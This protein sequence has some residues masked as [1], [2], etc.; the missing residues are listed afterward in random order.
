MKPVYFLVMVGGGVFHICLERKK[1][2]VH[3]GILTSHAIKVCTI[4]FGGAFK[5]KQLADAL[6]ISPIWMA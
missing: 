4:L 6:S 5:Q 1:K 2:K 3:F